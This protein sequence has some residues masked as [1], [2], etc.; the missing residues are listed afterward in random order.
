MTSG[1][2][3]HAI[4]AQQGITT[5]ASISFLE[6]MIQEILLG[7]GGGTVTKPIANTTHA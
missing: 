3:K 1:C 7:G 2:I 5:C 6:L 4:L